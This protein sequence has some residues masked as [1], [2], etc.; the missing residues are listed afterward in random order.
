MHNKNSVGST[1]KVFFFN[2]TVLLMAQICS[3]GSTS[4]A[5]EEQT[6]GFL[7][8]MSSAKLPAA[9]QRPDLQHWERRGIRD[10]ETTS[11]LLGISQTPWKDLAL[12]GEQTKSSTRIFGPL[13]SVKQQSLGAGESHVWAA[14]SKEN[15]NNPLCPPHGSLPY[16]SQQLTFQ[17]VNNITT[18]S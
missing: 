3:A 5:K 15:G 9:L 6:G 10:K 14:R 11:V 12:E 1:L 17:A 8:H 4:P 16:V 13:L 7:P 18:Q 2:S